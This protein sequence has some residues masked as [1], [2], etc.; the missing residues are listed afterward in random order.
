MPSIWRTPPAWLGCTRARE[1]AR[2]L[3]PKGLDIRTWPE[4]VC[5]HLVVEIARRLARARLQELDGLGSLVLYEDPCCFLDPAVP[6]L[7]E[8]VSAASVRA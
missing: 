6:F 7:L 8:N 4:G 5:S 2:T 1:R 3:R